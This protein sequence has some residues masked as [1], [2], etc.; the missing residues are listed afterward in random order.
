MDPDALCRG[1]FALYDGD[2]RVGGALQHD[3]RLEQGD[4][5][6]DEPALPAVGHQ[7][8]VESAGGFAADAATLDLDDA[9]AFRRGVRGHR[10]DDSGAAFC[11]VDDCVFR[12]ACVQLRRT[13][14]RRTVFI[15]W[16]RRSTNSRFSWVSAAFF[17][18]LAK[19]SRRA[20]SVMSPTNCGNAPAIL[21]LRGQWHLRSRREFSFAS[22]FITVLF[23]RGRK[24]TSQKFCWRRK[25]FLLNF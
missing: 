3:G 12:A 24:Q 1:G 6:L 5:F 21:H 2:Q 17:S 19:S 9:T 20:E 25:I 23:C 8:A 14:S 10:A 18:I 15:Y 7:A 13:T 4:G 22:A 16:R 11:A